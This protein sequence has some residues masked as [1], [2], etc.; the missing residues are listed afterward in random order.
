MRAGFLVDNREAAV[1]DTAAE[2]S[3]LAHV[4]H[5]CRPSITALAADDFVGIAV[6]HSARRK[7]GVAAIVG[8][9]GKLSKM[10]DGKMQTHAAGSEVNMTLLARLAAEAGASGAICERILLAN[11][12]IWINASSGNRS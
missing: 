12:P 4:V 8:M 5:S 3:H 7:L 11:S 1:L 6:K 9:I 2:R 10:A